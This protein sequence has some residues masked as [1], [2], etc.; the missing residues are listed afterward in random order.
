MRE[1]RVQEILGDPNIQGDEARHYAKFHLTV[2]VREKVVTGVMLVKACG[3]PEPFPEW[4]EWAESAKT[5]EGVGLGSS[6][7]EV[8][9]ALGAPEHERRIEASVT[10]EVLSYPSRGISLQISEAGACVITVLPPRE[11]EARSSGS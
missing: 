3:G 6:A 7:A 5:R 2:F 9:K 4:L 10:M 11:G 8:R 1:S